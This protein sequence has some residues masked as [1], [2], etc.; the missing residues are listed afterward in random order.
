MM[1]PERSAAE[2]AGVELHQV[3]SDYVRAESAPTG[4]RFCPTCAGPMPPPAGGRRAICPNCG[5]V[6]YRNPSPG[7]VVLVADGDRVLLGKRAAGSFRAGKWSLPGGFVEYEEDFLEAGIR[8][9][10]EETNID[11]RI[12]SI[13]NVVSN[14][15][16]P[17]LH[18]LVVVLLAEPQGGALRAGDDFEEVCWHA[19]LDPLPE[20]AFPADTHI[21]QHFFEGRV[22]GIPV[23]AGRRPPSG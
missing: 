4:P 5:Y 17:G 15:L 11:V 19:R 18:T 23:D 20:M 3:F 2:A 10:R 7:V 13:L 9:T 6:H 14:F 1:E 8:E 12:R 21:V 16:A 22:E